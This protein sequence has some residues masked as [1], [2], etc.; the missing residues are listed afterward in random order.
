MKRQSKANAFCNKSVEITAERSNAGWITGI[1]YDITPKWSILAHLLS[2]WIYIRY[3]SE[4]NI[5][6]LFRRI[7]YCHKPYWLSAS[8]NKVMAQY[9]LFFLASIVRVRCITKTGALSGLL[10]TC[11]FSSLKDASHVTFVF[12]KPPSDLWAKQHPGWL[13]TASVS[14]GEIYTWLIIGGTQWRYWQR[15]AQVSSYITLKMYMC[16]QKRSKMDCII[17][18]SPSIYNDHREVL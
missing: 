9:Y 13:K 10:L 18:Y 7:S 17:I 15:V 3:V 8:K 6:L 1:K 16:S 2:L 12:D 14:E 5:C 4:P 11:F